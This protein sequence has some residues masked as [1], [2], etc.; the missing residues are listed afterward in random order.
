[1]S[2]N[3]I[4]KIEEDLRAYVAENAKHFPFIYQFCEINVTKKASAKG[5]NERVHF[6]HFGTEAKTP[7]PFYK[8]ISK[9]IDFKTID[10]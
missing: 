1:M 4:K 2:K 9:T 8:P 7:I 6:G 3:N 10:E 5:D